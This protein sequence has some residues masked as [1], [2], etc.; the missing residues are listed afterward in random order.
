MQ[1]C[2]PYHIIRLALIS[3][4]LRLLANKKTCWNLPESKAGFDQYLFVCIG[5]IGDDGDGDD[6]DGDTGDDGEGKS[7]GPG[8]GVLVEAPP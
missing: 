3:N 7:A 2:P 1:I 5:N 6:D 4:S 8:G